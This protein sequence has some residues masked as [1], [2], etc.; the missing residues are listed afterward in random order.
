MG[1]SLK[2]HKLLWGRSGNKCAFADCRND[3]IADET[4]TDDESI[5]GDEAHIVARSEDGPRGVSKLTEEERDKY[6][7]LILLCRKHHKIIDDQPVFFS[8]E[9]LVEI[10][11]NHE[12]WISDSLTVD[13]EKNKDD[14]AYATYIDEIVKILDFEN[15]NAWTSWL[16]GSGQSMSYLK[17]K[18]LE[19]LP[20]FIVT[21]FWPNRYLE[22]EDSVLNLKAVLN[23]L[24]KVFHE[25]IVPKSLELK[26]DE[27]L[28]TKSV[29]TEKFYKLIYHEDVK[30][31][32]RL[33]EEYEFHVALVDDLGLELTRA[34]NLLIERIRKHISP[35]YRDKEGK[36]LITYGPTMD[37]SYYSVKVEYKPDEK[38]NKYPYPGLKQFMSER[39]KRD[40]GFGKGVSEKY[41]PF[42]FD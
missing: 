31:Y 22:L 25:H 12:K 27:D 26:P 32:D 36:L 37:F 34:G 16:F 38:T 11:K 42:K 35:M 4:E 3:L 41:L 29:Y 17:F 21:R 10:K 14:L 2:T 23:D 15:W 13:T 20:S 1:I 19:K 6:D 9:K 40:F 5:I 24:L 7:N 39:E 18:E 30:V 28:E 8:V 33:M